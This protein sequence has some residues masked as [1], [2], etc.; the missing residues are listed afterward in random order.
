[1]QLDELDDMEPE[2]LRQHLVTLDPAQSASSSQLP[3]AD[4]IDNVK[5]LLVT[6]MHETYAETIA[7]EL[8]AH[9]V[10]PCVPAP[11]GEAAAPSLAY[12]DL[13]A[14]LEQV[15]KQRHSEAQIIPCSPEMAA[16]ASSSSARSGPQISIG[17]GAASPSHGARPPSPRRR[18]SMD[19]LLGPN[20]PI[21]RVMREAASPSP[22]NLNSLGTP[23]PSPTLHAIAAP[24]ITRLTLLHSPRSMESVAPMDMASVSASSGATSPRLGATAT[25][26]IF[27]ALSGTSTGS[28]AVPHSSPTAVGSG[29][30]SPNGKRTRAQHDAVV[31]SAAANGAPLAAAHLSFA[32]ASTGTATPPSSDCESK[33][34]TTSAEPAAKRARRGATEPAAAQPSAPTSSEA[35]LASASGAS[36]TTRQRIAGAGGPSSAPANSAISSAEGANRVERSSAKRARGGTDST[37]KPVK[38]ARRGAR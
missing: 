15:V 35:I 17:V 38:S 19:I 28:G 10:I 2:V 23:G 9:G 8:S 32:S 11:Y 36:R 26:S 22:S 4:L 16:A 27:S 3:R 37:G 20:S 33:V 34:D 5:A 12:R 25:R 13:F 7:A 18:L 24:A 31:T 21:S 14:Q 29:L 1:M 30:G 6:R